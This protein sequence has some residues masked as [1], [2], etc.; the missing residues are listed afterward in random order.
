M[1]KLRRRANSKEKEIEPIV[2]SNK[3]KFKIQAASLK[4]KTK[5]NKMSKKIASLGFISQVIKVE[6]KGKG[7]L[8]RVIVSGFENKV[9]ADEAAQKISQKT[10]TNC[11]IKSINRETKKN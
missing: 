3:Q 4:D 5:A 6:I 2:A 1:R 10:G 11:I 9:K 8:F 7:T